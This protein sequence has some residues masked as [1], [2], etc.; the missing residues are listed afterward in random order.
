M[1]GRARAQRRLRWLS[2][3]PLALALLTL[4]PVF[5]QS[6]SG[7]TL[8]KSVANDIYVV[9]EFLETHQRIET[10]C[11]TVE[12]L[13]GNP[14]AFSDWRTDRQPAIDTVMQIRKLYEARAIKM[15]GDRVRE[16]FTIRQANAEAAA[17]KASEAFSQESASRLA[18]ACEVWSRE[19]TDPTSLLRG[20]V[21]QR[22][23]ALT[24]NKTAIII[25]LNDN[26]NW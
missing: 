7:Q 14:R 1:N 26:S 21:D 18:A 17:E 16:T 12:D 9:I 25:A 20:G 8:L 19:L 23:D 3:L 22:I 10:T 4:A 13:Q 2:R 24:D 15:G 11:T 5:A 6:T